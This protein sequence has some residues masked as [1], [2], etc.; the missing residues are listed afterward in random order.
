MSTYIRKLVV[1]DAYTSVKWRNTPEIWEYTKYKPIKIITIED[2][3]KWINEVIRDV[4]CCRF[5]II[6]ESQYVGNIYITN[7]QDGVGEYHIFIGE[8]SFWGR[9]VAKSAS[10]LLIKYAKYVKKINKLILFVNEENLGA[11]KLY[12]KLR[13]IRESKDHN[14]ICMSLDLN[15]K[16]EK[17]NHSNIEK[18]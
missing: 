15:T 11:L 12:K 5:A 2:E 17:A 18:K 13:F 4:T 1:N 8:K 3:L 6:S 14:W 10:I 7:I 9:G 16:L